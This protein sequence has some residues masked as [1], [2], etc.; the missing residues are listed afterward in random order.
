[1]ARRHAGAVSTRVLNVDGPDQKGLVH[2]ITGLLLDAG[3][4]IVENQE[5]VDRP[6]NWFF[7]R[8]EVEG[9]VDEA[10]LLGKL[11]EALG[12]GARIRLPA[13]APR[14]LVIMASKEHHCVGDLLV[15]NMF[16]ESNSETLCVISN[17]ETLRGLVEGFGVRFHFVGSEGKSR[18]EHEAAVLEALAGYDFE[19]M[20][21]AKYM[22]I[23]SA[24]FVRRFEE[25]IINI[26]HSFLPAFIGAKPYHQAYERGVKVI[27]ATAHF[28]TDALDQGPIIVQEVMPV[29]HSHSPGDLARAGRDVEQIVLARALRLVL[30]DRVFLSG[31]RTILFD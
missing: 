23:L 3:L 4:N 9:V 18:E 24:D 6:S 2:R 30:E 1:M 10:G 27:G 20:V 5:F 26:H 28:V 17:H 12:A 31:N 7:M 29:H 8:T 11:R 25:R 16:R 22:R 19:Y 13:L 14:R 15:R 21:L